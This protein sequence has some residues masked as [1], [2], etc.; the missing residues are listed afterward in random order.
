MSADSGHSSLMFLPSM[1][2]I[3][4]SKNFRSDPRKKVQVQFRSMAQMRASAP[5]MMALNCSL[6]FSASLRICKRREAGGENRISECETRPGV[7]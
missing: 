4:D 5:E 6:R 7:A 3:C 2:P 1:A